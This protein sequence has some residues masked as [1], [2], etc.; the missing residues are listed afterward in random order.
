MDMNTQISKR[1]ARGT[2]FKDA[3]ERRAVNA[4]EASRL[5]RALRAAT[6]LI[7]EARPVGRGVYEISPE[8]MIAL[9]HNCDSLRHKLEQHDRE[10]SQEGGE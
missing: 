5:W 7:D 2:V 10:L 9:R 4:K 8:T 6:R 1:P 3:E